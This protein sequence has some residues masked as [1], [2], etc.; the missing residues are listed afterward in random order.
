MS[1]TACWPLVATWHRNGLCWPIAVASSPGTATNNPYSGGPRRVTRLCGSTRPE[2]TWITDEM[3]TAYNELHRQG[4]A[5]SL[6]AWNAS[7]DLVGGLYGLAIGRCFFAESMF[8]LETNASRVL[9]VHLAHQLQLSG[10]QIVDCQVASDHL[11]RMGATT[12]SRRQ[13][14]SI[15]EHNVD[16]QPDALKWAMDW[17]WNKQEVSA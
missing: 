7:G 11:I 10:Y 16:Q 15:L 9:M 2:G 1:L 13:F 6:E 14:L 3:E 8:S 4:V 5:H 12:I 17:R